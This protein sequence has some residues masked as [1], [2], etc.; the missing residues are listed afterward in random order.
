MRYAFPSFPELLYLLHSSYQS[1]GFNCFIWQFVCK[2]LMRLLNSLSDTT[3][4]CDCRNLWYGVAF[5][6]F[7]TLHRLGLCARN[8][9][10]PCPRILF[11]VDT[12]IHV[13]AESSAL[14]YLWDGLIL[15]SDYN[16]FVVLGAKL[17]YVFHPLHDG[18]VTHTQ[19]VL[20]FIQMISY[21]LPH[22]L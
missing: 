15:E 5:H 4:L 10:Q 20:L 18:R 11:L 1:F 13:G 12:L 7:D 19:P 8:L 16:I 6:F 3:Y 21:L 2:P 9:V 17:V 14:F 22:L